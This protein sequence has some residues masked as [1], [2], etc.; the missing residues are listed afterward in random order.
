MFLRFYKQSF[1]V[2]VRGDTGLGELSDALNVYTVHCTPL[3]PYEQ[4]ATQTLGLQ[5]SEVEKKAP[6]AAFQPGKE[7]YWTRTSIGYAGKH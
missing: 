3:I 5:E 6:P 1:F 4:F 7:I 2:V